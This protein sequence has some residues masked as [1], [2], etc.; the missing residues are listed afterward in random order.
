[1][2]HMHRK[3][4]DIDQ[5]A[6]SIDRRELTASGQDLGQGDEVNE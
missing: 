6:K 2:G 5:G 4:G 3:C 1:M